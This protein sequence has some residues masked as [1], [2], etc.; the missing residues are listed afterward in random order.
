MEYFTA[1]TTV[2]LVKAAG[3]VVRTYRTSTKKKV[4]E[5]VKPLNC[6]QQCQKHLVSGIGKSATP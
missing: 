3:L 1:I 6:I 5:K 2:A 4:T